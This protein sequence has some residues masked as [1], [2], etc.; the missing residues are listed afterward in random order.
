MHK[1]FLLLIVVAL[2]MQVAADAQTCISIVKPAD[3]LTMPCTLA[4]T[5]FTIKVPGLHAN[6]TY[7][8]QSNTYNP[9]PFINANT[10]VGFIDGEDGMSDT[11]TLPFPFSLYDSAYNKMVIAVDGFI[12]F[13]K[14]LA[15]TSS[16]FY[17]LGY[18]A[19][20][21]TFHPEATIVAIK[22]D[23]WLTAPTAIATTKVDTITLGSAPCRKFVISWNNIPQ[24][25]CTSNMV[26]TQIVLYEGSNIVET[27][28][29]NRSQCLSGEGPS[30]FIMGMQNWTRNAAIAPPGRSQSTVA[31]SNESWKYSP[32]G[33]AFL[34]QQS[35]LFLNGVLQGVGDTTRINSDSLSVYFSGV[36]PAPGEVQNLKIITTYKL[37]T[38]SPQLFVVT[39]SIVVKKL[40]CTPLSFTTQLTNPTCFGGTNGKIVIHASGGVSPY[41][42]SINGTN[43]FTDSTFSNLSAGTYTLYTKDNAGT[44]VSSS[45]TLTA[46]SAV[47]GTTT[48]T[49]VLC[50]GG[51]TGSITVNASGGTPSYQYSLNGG[52]FQVSNVF[53]G[54]TANTYSIIIKDA[55]NCTTTISATATQPTAVN[56]TAVTVNVLCNGGATGSITVTATGGTPGYQYALNGGTYQASNLFSGLTANTYSI[57]VKDANNCVFTFNATITQP[58]AAVNATIASSNVLCNGGATGSITVNATG[59]TPG[60]QYALNGGTY[61]ASNIF[62]GLIAGTYS[63]TVKDANNC[64][65]LVSNIVITQPA[66][67]LSA[68]RV[69]ANALCF[70]GST[71]SI[72]IT[73]T[74]GT[75]GYQYALNGGGYQGSNIF[76]GLAAG[77]YSVTVRDANN[78]T[79]NISPIVISQPVVLTASV[80]TQGAGC[81]V[82][83]SGSITVTANGGTPAYQYALNGGT[84][85]ASNFFS[86][87]AGG[88]YSV[89]VKDANGC[90]AGIEA[91]VGA[92]FNLVVSTI[93]DATLCAGTSIPLTT[94]SNGTSFSWSPATGLN[95]SGAQSPIASPTTFTR[96]I[97][98]ASLGPCTAKDTVNISVNPLPSVN[99]GADITL[100]LGD[101]ANINAI[102][103]P[104]I[105]LWT[106]STG[107]SSTNSLITKAKP[108]LT[109]TYTLRATNDQGCTATDDVLVTVLP[110]CFKPANAF[111]P[112]GDGINDKWQ[113]L[114]GGSCTKSVDVTVFNR[115][116][117]IVFEGK[118]YNNSWDGTYSGKGLPDGTYYWVIKLVYLDGRY[119]SAKG[120]VTILR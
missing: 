17:G 11:I 94:T 103:S 75:P 38:N 77:S 59:G 119:I 24:F 58:A 53:S 8:V 44:I 63:V 55:N 82:I 113:V 93:N 46:P 50:N 9:Y 52:T 13:N 80:V 21:H 22:E 118:N 108:T 120:S 10:P 40:P 14:S 48:I 69:F 35:K 92:S 12:T 90:T 72:T 41:T 66:N 32:T 61:Q 49:N 109:T 19:L 105:Y 4:C 74:G 106:P 34:F 112:N 28:I 104:G 1:K 115:N 47:A 84:Y 30:S 86:G 96:Y 76:S 87:L 88:N 18:P 78:C 16:V 6:N 64:T 81:G 2:F 29:K 25:F 85:Q 102:A 100:I 114:V 70:G 3:T 45:A 33:P 79:V 15:K 51:S 5:N 83:P 73:A 23:L 110:D 117:S 20:P 43:Y 97:V 107:L 26:T 7:S 71:G 37:A 31:L 39:D 36:C 42:F 116:G 95:N 98:T 54:L 60:Y 62:N 27:Y 56:A 101:E 111:T 67:A 57:S 68:T 89:A 91:I 65:K 99:A